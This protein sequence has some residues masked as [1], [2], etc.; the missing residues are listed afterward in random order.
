MRSDESAV[1]AKWAETINVL[2]GERFINFT[3]GMCQNA[4]EVSRFA[5]MTHTFIWANTQ[6]N[7]SF[8]S[9]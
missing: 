1:F 5:V 3:V 8:D 4:L 2:T 9:G 7:L 6:H